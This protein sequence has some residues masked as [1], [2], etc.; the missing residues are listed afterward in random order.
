MVIVYC[1]AVLKNQNTI[2]S[3]YHR[4]AEVFEQPSDHI[5]VCFI[6]VKEQLCAPVL[7]FLFET[8]TVLNFHNSHI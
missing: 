8:K 4:P 3:T 5:F 2:L 1:A 7:I 6:R